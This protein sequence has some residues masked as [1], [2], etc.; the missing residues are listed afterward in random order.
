[1]D[2]KA[3]RKRL[4]LKLAEVSEKTGYSVATI[5]GLERL[6]EGS[7]RLKTALEDFYRKRNLI[8]EPEAEGI[9]L[10]EDEFM[11]RG[12]SKSLFSHLSIE[13]LQKNMADLTNKLSSLRGPD[14]KHVL[15][16]IRSIL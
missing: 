9:V 12:V 11:E 13:A 6:G 8:A 4:G 3:E 2:Y 7:D 10:R 5:N 1:M 14:R 16:N 15:G